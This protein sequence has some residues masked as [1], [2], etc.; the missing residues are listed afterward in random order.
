MKSETRNI[1]WL[2]GPAHRLTAI[3]QLSMKKEILSEDDEMENFS[4]GELYQAAED[5]LW[6]ARR[7]FDLG[8]QASTGGNISIRVGPDHFLTKPTGLGLTDCARSSLVLV[9]GEG[10]IRQ[11]SANPTKEV[12]VHLGIFKT[13]GDIHGI[14]HYHAPFATAYAVKE[15]RLPLPTVHA[16]RILRKIPLIPKSPEGSVELA[17]ATAHACRDQEVMGLLL[18]GHGI[19]A[20]GKTLRQA[21]YIAE[22][23]EECAKIGWV[24]KSID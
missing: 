16:Q 5:F 4:E 13:R 6:A 17:S 18:A 1:L 23:M 9:D 21:Q 24:S 3:A 19:L 20:I 12:G 14:V 11:G 15:R 8:L 22:L 7:A 10:N 2:P